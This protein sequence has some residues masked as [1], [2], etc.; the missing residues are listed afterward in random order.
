MV[1]SLLKTLRSFGVLRI[2]FNGDRTFFIAVWN[3]NYYFK[4][5]KKYNKT[6]INKTKK[7]FIEFVK[8]ECKKYGIKCD[9][10]PVKYLRLSG[11]IKCSGYFDETNKL[12]V[13]ATKSK[14]WFY[15]LVHEYAHLTQWVDNCKPWKL[16]SDNYSIDFMDRWLNGHYVRNPEKHI[17]MVRDLELDNEKRTVKLIKKFGLGDHK[18]YIKSANAYLMFYNHI[19]ETRK[20]SNPKKS[21]YRNKAII[22]VMSDGFRMNYDK[23]SKKVRSAFEKANVC[24]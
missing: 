16:V 8:L 1:Y 23:M 24:I 5:N 15:I 3:V 18:R 22:S 14:D 13:C 19:K 10:R 7:Q 9:L 6:M 21:P 20:W 17:N 4:F 12:L 2:L 11:N